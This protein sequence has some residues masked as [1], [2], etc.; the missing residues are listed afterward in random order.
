MQCRP[1]FYLQHQ[2]NT[3]LE[4]IPKYWTLP[5]RQSLGSH[6]VGHSHGLLLEH[7]PLH[8]LDLQR[9]AAG[10]PVHLNGRVVFWVTNGPSRLGPAS[11][12][13]AQ[14]WVRPLEVISSKA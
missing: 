10:P 7:P 2:S 8:I 1:A 9:D 3:F 11:L 6:H 5:V 12:A 13:C 14:A 4:T